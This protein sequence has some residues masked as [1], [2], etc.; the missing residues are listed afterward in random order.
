MYADIHVN[1]GETRDLRELVERTKIQQD[2][3]SLVKVGG[4]FDV[5]CYITS[6]TLRMLSTSGNDQPMKENHVTSRYI[7]ERGFFKVPSPNG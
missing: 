4:P 2:L 6:K 5:Y 3:F 7:V 1:L